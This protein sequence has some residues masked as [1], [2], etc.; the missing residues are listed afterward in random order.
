MSTASSPDPKHTSQFVAG[1]AI[2]TA[3]ILW[4]SN[5]VTASDDQSIHVYAPNGQLVR[6]LL[7]HEGGVWA[8]ALRGDTLVS[9]ATDKTI[10]IWDL[11]TGNCTHVFRRHASTVRCLAIAEPEEDRAG[12]LWP[13]RPLIVTG[14]R[15][16]TVCVW[17]FPQPGDPEHKGSDGDNN[18]DDVSA[19]CCPNPYHLFRI[20]G[21]QD[22]IRAVS[23]RGRRAASASY[24]HTVRI[25]DIVAGQCLF[26][27]T[28]HTGKVYSVI[29]DAG[30]DQVY[31]G[32]MDHTVRVWD[33]SR[34]VCK[35]VLSRH[36]SL[37]GLLSMSPSFLV[38]GGTEGLVC[39]WDPTSGD[40]VQ[41]FQH[42][43]AVTA[44]QHDDNKV[45]TGSD[46]L[47]R[48]M[49]FKSGK[50][51]DLLSDERSRVVS[52]VAFAGQLCVAVTKKDTTAVDVWNYGE[53]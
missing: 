38:S 25:W 50:V 33:L 42:K 51:R 3:L 29:I 37:V 21:H 20:D 43:F 1:S 7:G 47:V 10:R 14:S 39:V 2:V 27:L 16:R 28:G 13:K 30:R 26:V 41:T 35:H 48:V 11:Q 15:D 12:E 46:G 45:I 17:V 53:V 40:L 44:I 23:A 31:S 36:E 18:S 32:S 24:D 4:N 22:S 9:G 49:Y 52:C 5:I 6:S 19:N 34:G 8:L